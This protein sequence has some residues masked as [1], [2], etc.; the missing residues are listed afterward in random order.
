MRT[1]LELAKDLKILQD[2]E[3]VISG[4]KEKLCAEYAKNFCPY[5]V[6]DIV[7]NKGYS[8][9]GKRIEITKV[10]GHI[11][12]VKELEWAVVGD[13]IKQD[14]SISKISECGWDEWQEKNT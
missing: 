13:L 4:K 6:G 3:G 8:F 9:A 10:S 1:K 14:G 7:K 5:K 2:E 12:F 11:G